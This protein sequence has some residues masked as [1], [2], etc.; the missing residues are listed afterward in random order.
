MKTLL[1]HLYKAKVLASLLVPAESTAIRNMKQLTEEIASGAV[2]L[3]VASP[4]L[5]SVVR[6]YKCAICTFLPY[7]TGSG[8]LQ[9]HFNE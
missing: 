1:Q 4:S 2:K 5:A 6:T 9:C 3:R 7:T 8:S